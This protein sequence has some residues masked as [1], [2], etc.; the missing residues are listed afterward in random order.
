MEKSP[1]PRAC[2]LHLVAEAFA[3]GRKALSRSE[4]GQ[5]VKGRG[6]LRKRD[7]RRVLIR[8]LAGLRSRR[9][10]P[11]KDRGVDGPSFHLQKGTGISIQSQSW[12]RISG[13][14]Q[15]FLKW[16]FFFKNMFSFKF[17]PSFLLPPVSFPSFSVTSRCSLDQWTYC[18]CEIS[19]HVVLDT[20]KIR[21]WT[22]VITKKGKQV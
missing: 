9:Y 19:I 4:A 11:R 17:H 13:V 22:H 5:Q 7:G 2:W 10:L 12:L 16:E 18:I 1:Y 21:I 6:A 20:I 8:T 3:V 15:S 14:K